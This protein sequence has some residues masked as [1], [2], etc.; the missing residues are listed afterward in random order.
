MRLDS[1]LHA[2]PR[3]NFGST[4]PLFSRTRPG[5]ES[6]HLENNGEVLP[7]LQLRQGRNMEAN[8]STHPRAV[9][10]TWKIRKRYRREYALISIPTTSYHFRTGDA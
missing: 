4:S 3:R 6:V 8:P 2:R 1:M 10:K 7:K 9:Q 5:G